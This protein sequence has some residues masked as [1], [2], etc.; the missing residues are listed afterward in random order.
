MYPT[1]PAAALEAV[2]ESDVIGTA[3]EL[4]E[5]IVDLTHRPV[6]GPAPVAVPDPPVEAAEA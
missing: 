5:A 3:R 6:P 1:M 4:A 2:G